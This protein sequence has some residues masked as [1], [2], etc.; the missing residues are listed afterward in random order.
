MQADWRRPVENSLSGQT[1]LGERVLYGTAASQE[2]SLP[3]PID[4]PHLG[5]DSLSGWTVP[6]GRVSLEVRASQEW[7][8]RQCL[9]GNSLS[10]QTLP[11]E[12]VSYEME[13]QPEPLDSSLRQHPVSDSLS[14]QSTPRERVVRRMEAGNGRS[15]PDPTRGTSP[16]GAS[17]LEPGASR[18]GACP[19]QRAGGPWSWTD[20]TNGECSLGSSLPEPYR[21]GGE[22]GP[23]MRSHQRS[24]LQTQWATAQWDAPFPSPAGWEGRQT[25]TWGTA[26]CRT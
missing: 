3:D 20:V 2:W 1:S 8:E 26:C 7:R 22:A 6:R 13:A 23:G 21:S 4:R 17:L 18:G 15:S 25:Q 14:G 9:V 10:G 24:Q 12:R 5:E 11:R 19:G 16:R